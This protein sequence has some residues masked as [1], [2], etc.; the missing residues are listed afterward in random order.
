MQRLEVVD[1]S[2]RGSAPALAGSGSTPD[3]DGGP[4]RVAVAPRRCRR[5]RRRAA[6]PS[7]GYRCMVD[8]QVGSSAPNRTWA[9]IASSGISFTKSARQ[10]HCCPGGI[11]RVERALQGRVRHRLRRRAAAARASASS[12]GAIARGRVLLARAGVAPDDAAHLAQVELLGERRAGRHAEEG[13]EA[14]QLAR[15]ARQEVA[16]DRAAPRRSARAAR[17]SGRRSTVPTSCSRNRNEVTTPKL[18]PP[19]RIAQ[20]RSGFSSALARTRCRRPAP[21]RPRAGC[22]WSGRT[23]A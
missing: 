11:E 16:V 3:D 13:E 6:A 10:Y 21:C 22:R 12:S 5:P 7:I 23:C 18:P 9:S 14:V 15:R 1:A 2:S 19:P 17:T 20:K 4:L 8:C